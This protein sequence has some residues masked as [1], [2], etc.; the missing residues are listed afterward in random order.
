VSTPTETPAASP[1]PAT[2]SPAPKSEHLTLVEE[3]E[4]AMQKLLASIER[5]GVIAVHGIEQEYKAIKSFVGYGLQSL[6]A[7]L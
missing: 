1:T 6:K 7:K 5:E 4:A 2:A 3:V